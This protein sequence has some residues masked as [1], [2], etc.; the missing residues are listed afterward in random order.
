V[1]KAIDLKDA[2]VFNK[3]F[4]MLK[5]VIVVTAQWKEYHVLR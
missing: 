1:E 2:L 3:D 5:I 4:Q